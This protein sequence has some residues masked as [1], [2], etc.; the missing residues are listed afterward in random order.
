M[1]P[2]PFLQLALVPAMQEVSVSEPPNMN[3]PCCCA[4]T[5]ARVSTKTKGRSVAVPDPHAVDVLKIRRV[6]IEWPTDMSPGISQPFQ[7]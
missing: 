7:G 4:S 6:H 5:R 1:H 2:R 3:P